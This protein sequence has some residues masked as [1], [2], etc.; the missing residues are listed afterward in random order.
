M[1]H[2]W[3]YHRQREADTLRALRSHPL[4]EVHPKERRLPLVGLLRRRRASVPARV[5]RIA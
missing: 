5:F 1:T 3:D 4:G 2:H